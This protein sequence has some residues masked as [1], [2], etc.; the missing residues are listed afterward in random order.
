MPPDH[1]LRGGRRLHAIAP[2]APTLPPKVSVVTVV[3]NGAATLDACIRSV[4]AQT[5]PNVE[6]VIV[7]GGSTD[8]TLDILHRHDATLGLWVSEP[9]SGIYDA[10]NKG[11]RLCAGQHYIVL[12]CDDVLLPT[13]AESFMRHADRG[14][15]VFAWVF[16]Q[17]P[18]KGAM[19]IRAHS[20]GSLIHMEAHRRFGFYDQSYRIA[21]DTKFL[22][23]ARR[24]GVTVAIDDNVGVFA[25]GGASGSYARNVA[26]HARAMRESGA[27]GALRGLAWTAPRRV[28]AWLRG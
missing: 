11:V 23:T 8:G 6:H 12:G 15:V 26:E 22:E 10:L 19:R 3:R 4:A 5:Y 21:A 24:A 25:A 18:R 2:D 16:F 27:W 28:L 20:A 9:D 14:W 1:L 17:S 7:D 13:A